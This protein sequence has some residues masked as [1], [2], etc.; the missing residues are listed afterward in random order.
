VAEVPLAGR[1]IQFGFVV[2][3]AVAAETSE[4]FSAPLDSGMFRQRVGLTLLTLLD[5]VLA[6]FPS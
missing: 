2:Q 3:S 1:R 5:K 4:T 6:C